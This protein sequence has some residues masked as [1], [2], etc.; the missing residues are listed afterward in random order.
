[1]LAVIA[2]TGTLPLAACK[3]LL[4]KNKSFFVISLFPE[5]NKVALRKNLPEHIEIISQ[6]IY[7]VSSILYLLKLR[8]TKQI[9]FIGKVDKRNLLK[10]LKLDWFAVKM[11]ATIATK[12][13]FS[14]M[15]R[16]GEE[17]RKH[18]MEVIHQDSVLDRL[19]VPSGILCGK[20]TDSIR[21]DIDY[22]MKM[23]KK[24]SEL[25]IGQ[26]VI[27]KDGMVLAVEAIE[28]TDACIKRGI[29]LGKS[30]VV[31]CKSAQPDHNKQ[32][33][34]PTLGIQSLHE[35]K[36]GEVAAIAWL[37]THTFIV[38]QKSFVERAQEF[39]ICLLSI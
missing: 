10:K 2:G 36:K 11:L 22:G 14:I 6:S 5:D 33:D 18:G 3:S 28:G 19:L 39:G 38:N 27:V 31:V 23:A 20:M 21:A 25:D 1:M 29:E 24:M 12:S 4:A 32:F 34:S 15:N 26:T 30:G 37:S 13:D 35:I 16:I 8:H 17:L 7:K 9:L